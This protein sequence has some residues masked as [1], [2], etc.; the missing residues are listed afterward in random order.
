[1][2]GPGDGIGEA[3]PGTARRCPS[4][5]PEGAEPA[6]LSIP[7]P[8]YTSAGSTIWFLI[9]ATENA[10]LGSPVKPEKRE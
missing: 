10:A 1:M 2:G 3:Q 4:R 6:G 5:R 7:L 9:R 8:E